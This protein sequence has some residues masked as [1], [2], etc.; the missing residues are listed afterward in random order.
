MVELKRHKILQLEN[1]AINPMAFL[2]V[3]EHSILHLQLLNCGVMT[4]DFER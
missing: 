2:S 4:G 3:K 1:F